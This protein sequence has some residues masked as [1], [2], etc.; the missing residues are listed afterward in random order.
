M[1]IAC[2]KFYWVVLLG[3]IT[4][5][6]WRK[7]EWAEGKVGCDAVW[8]KSSVDSIE[9]FGVHPNFIVVLNWGNGNGLPVGKDWPWLRQLS[10]TIDNFWKGLS[11]EPSAANPTGSW[12][13][14]CLG[15]VGDSVTSATVHCLCHLYYIICSLYLRTGRLG[16]PKRSLVQWTTVPIT[17]VDLGDTMDTHV[18][19]PRLPI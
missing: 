11:C 12:R 18:V 4:V 19:F 5:R 3:T 13:N 10:L 2:S 7:D 8:R 6:D 17:A 14:E 15:P 16:K 9:S 1:E